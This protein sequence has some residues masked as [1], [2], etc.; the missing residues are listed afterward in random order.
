MGY[1]TELVGKAKAQMIK[2]YLQSMADLMVT[3]GRLKYTVAWSSYMVSD[4]TRTVLGEVD[5]GWGK[6][7]YG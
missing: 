2:E 7:V 4:L 1:T 6:S 5:Y 3:E